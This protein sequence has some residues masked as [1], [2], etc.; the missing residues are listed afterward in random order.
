MEGALILK[1]NVFF[2]LLITL[3]I[4]NSILYANWPSFRNNQARQAVNNSNTITSTTAYLR[5]SLK[6]GNEGFNIAQPTINDNFIYLPAYDGTISKINALDGSIVA[7]FKC[8]GLI[9]GTGLVLNNTYYIGS[10]DGF[11]YAINTSD[12]SLKWKI[13][14]SSSISSSPLGASYNYPIDNIIFIDNSG[15]IYNFDNNGII[16]WQE[17]LSIAPDY[18]FNSPASNSDTQFSF[19]GENGKMFSPFLYTGYGYKRISE[20][21]KH[22][23]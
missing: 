7:S 12:M 3:L 5:W 6:I 20:F 19:T 15:K 11:A 23:R 18:F 13:K 14:L 16:Q 8:T 1:K 21:H 17:T 22:E 9:I 2:F 10:T 4:Y